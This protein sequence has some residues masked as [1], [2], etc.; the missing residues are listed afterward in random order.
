MT[1]RRLPHRQDVP[2]V[3]GAGVSVVIHNTSRG[4]AVFM[5][6]VTDSLG[7]VV[8]F[9][10]VD[11]GFHFQRIRLSPFRNCEPRLQYAR[12]L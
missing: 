6:W 9:P 1:E 3:R 5:R 11:E 7:N 4:P 8:R 12:L 2:V 10:A